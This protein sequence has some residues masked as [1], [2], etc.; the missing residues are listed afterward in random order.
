MRQ[1]VRRKLT[2]LIRQTQEESLEFLRRHFVCLP[3]RG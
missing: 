1:Q 3:A 2:A